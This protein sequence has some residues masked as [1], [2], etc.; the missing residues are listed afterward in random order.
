MF[1]E[2]I[3]KSKSVNHDVLKRKQTSFQLVKD[4]FVS[5]ICVGMN[6]EGV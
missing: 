1:F 6:A 2:N 3:I 5:E 4:E